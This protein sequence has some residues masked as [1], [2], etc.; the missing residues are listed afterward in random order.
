MEKL[1]TCDSSIFIGQRYFF[2]DGSQ[3]FL[4]FQTILNTSA[5]PTGL[6]GTIIVWQSKALPN[7]KNKAPNYI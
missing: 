2:N 3:N 6:T 4:I 5:V 7:Q 1:Q